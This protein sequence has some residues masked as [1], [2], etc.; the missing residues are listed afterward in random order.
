M[1]EASDEDSYP[2]V[3]PELR[4]YIKLYDEWSV[5]AVSA[6]Q[7]SDAVHQPLYHYT[8]MAGLLGMLQTE[9]VWFTDYKNQND[10]SEINFGI[11]S[12]WNVTSGFWPRSS[13]H[14]F[15]ISHVESFLTPD[16]I[17]DLL[18]FFITCLTSEKDNLGM[19]RAYADNGRG[20]SIGFAPSAFAIKD[21]QQPE[22]TSVFFAKVRYR[23]E[24]INPRHQRC[25]QEAAA[26]FHRATKEHTDLVNDETV[27]E[28]FTHELAL[29]LLALPVMW[30]CLTSKHE[31]YECE[32]EYRLAI[33]GSWVKP[34]RHLT[35]RLRGGELVPYI[36]QPVPLRTRGVISEIVIGPAAPKDSV[37]TVRNLL[38]S[39]GMD[40]G[41]S[42]ARS[43]IPYRA[44]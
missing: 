15:F 33:A 44:L 16:K 30:N 34:P 35:A 41:I 5:K 24:D 28:R 18:Y 7:A 4:K 26:F 43:E 17:A 9:T 13:A 38:T 22:S 29:R 11:N 27:C 37:R 10:P 3:H 20:V 32:Q 12:F 42:I 6:E 23:L 39:L 1:P 14:D 2:D 31:A 36:A 19:W 40:W 8:S 21:S 25:L